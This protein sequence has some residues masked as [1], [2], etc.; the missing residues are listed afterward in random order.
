MKVSFLIPTRGRP[1]LVANSIDSI[2]S[3]AKDPDSVGIYLGIDKDDQPSVDF[4]MKSKYKYEIFT[5][6]GYKNL[7]KYYNQ[8]AGMT[9]SDSVVI[10]NDDA[11]ML[12]KGWDVVLNQY[13]KYLLILR[14]QVI[15]HPHPFA[16]FPVVPKK[17]IEILGYLSPTAQIDRFIYEV[18]HNL[19]PVPMANIPVEC[20]HHRFDVSG[21]NKDATY[22]A[23]EYMEGDPS[24]PEHIDSPANQKIIKESAMKLLAFIQKNGIKSA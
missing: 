3:T 23:R 1:E 17:W 5:R 10:W 18:I 12:T 14:M 4:A 11:V 20:E 8:L 21:K 24:N 15:N 9:D 19:N 7:Y 22:E 13:D 6:M 16:L 2:L